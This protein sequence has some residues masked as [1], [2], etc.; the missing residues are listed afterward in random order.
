MFLYPRSKNRPF[1]LGPYPLETLERDGSVVVREAERA[2]LHE[3]AVPLPTGKLAQAAARYR[4]IFS[5]FSDG[6][7]APA[8]APVPDDLP[9][10]SVDIKGGAYFM[11]ADMAGIFLV[12]ETA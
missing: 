2:P 8:Q 1:H 11:D 4:V 10:R 5:E 6:E 3:P 9:R 7:V 12:P